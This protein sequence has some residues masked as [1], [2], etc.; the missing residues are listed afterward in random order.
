MAAAMYLEDGSGVGG[1]GGRS[2]HD[3]MSPLHFIMTNEPGRGWF[4]SVPLR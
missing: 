2:L 1:H 3:C 4:T